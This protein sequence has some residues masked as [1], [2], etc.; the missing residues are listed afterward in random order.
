MRRSL[1]QIRRTSR[2][3]VCVRGWFVGKTQP[4]KSMNLTVKKYSF[5]GAKDTFT[6]LDDSP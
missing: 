1:L 4:N 5:V 6:L 2:F 3:E